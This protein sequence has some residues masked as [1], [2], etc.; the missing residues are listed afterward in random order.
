MKKLLFAALFTI[1]FFTISH[2]QFLTYNLTNSSSTQ[3]WDYKMVDAGSGVVTTELGIL[4]GTNR[5]GVVAGYAF[6]LQF[7]AANSVGCGTGQVVPAPT[8]GVSVPI[9]CVVP[10]GLKYQVNVV[11]PFVVWHL[12]LKFG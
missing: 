9:V 2:A 11:V 12:E 5:S 10:A 8:P 3:T 6:P 7:K 1:G 4:P